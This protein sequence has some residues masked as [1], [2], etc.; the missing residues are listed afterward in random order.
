MDFNNFEES[1]NKT[2]AS[3]R[4]EL[5]RLRTGRAHSSLLEG[6]N[7]DYYGSSVPLNQLG[8]VSAPEARLLTI[9]VYDA[10][11]VE[12]VEKAIKISELGL[13][14]ARDGNVI[15]VPIPALT[16]ERRKELVKKLHKVAEEN[17]IAIRNVRRDVI[18]SFKKQEKDKEITTDDLKRAQEQAQKIT[19]RFIKE[20]DELLASKE[21]EMLE[22]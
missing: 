16:E 4:K 10:G 18:E 6:I 20:I 15:R 9:Q 22:V 3:F 13:N 1:G 5:A 11:A 19:D 17:R 8:N 14:P 2:I 7:V 21:K 12:A